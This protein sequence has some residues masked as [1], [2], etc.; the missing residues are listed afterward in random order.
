PSGVVDL[1]RDTVAGDGREALEAQGSTGEG[2]GV[3]HGR[4]RYWRRLSPRLECQLMALEVAPEDGAGSA[5][6]P[7]PLDGAT[8]TPK[9]VG[10][11][12]RSGALAVLTPE[13]RTR[14][15]RAREAIAAL[16]ARGDHLYGVT[17]GVGAL[18]AYRVP[19]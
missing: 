6:A 4:R 7:V 15:D 5:P 1:D 10:L 16:L 17:T 14:N 8:L 2:D 13:A 18:R 12:A 3:A 11:I 9:K 19:K